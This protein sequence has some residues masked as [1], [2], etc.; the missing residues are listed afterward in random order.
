MTTT[1]ENEL[2]VVASCPGMTGIFEQG[3]ALEEKGVLGALALDY[4]FDLSSVPY[5]WLP[6]NSLKKYL[7]KYYSSSLSLSK[8]YT[9]PFYSTFVRLHNRLSRDSQKKNQLVYWHNEKF[10]KWVAKNVLEK[11]NLAFGY[12]STSLYTF[13]QAKQSNLPCILY[14]PIACAEKALELLDE[15]RK[16]FPQFANTL[17]YNWFPPEEIKNKKEE[18]FLADAIICASTFTK[19]SL[20]EQGVKAEKIFVEPYGVDQ[21][22]FSPSKEKYTNFSVIWASSYTQ[23]KGIVYLLEALARKPVPN[24]ELVLAGYPFGSDPVLMYEDQVKVNRIGKVSNEEISKIMRKC[25]VHVFPTLVEGFGRNLIE[26]MSSGLPVIT[27]PNCAGP[28]LIEDGVTGF[29]VPIRD[30]DAICEKLLWIYKNPEPS[31]EMG[32]RAKERVASLTK[33]N[34]RHRFAD[35]VFSVWKANR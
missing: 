33:A 32:Q 7:R 28:D 3:V 1:Y 21:E 22:L 26:A 12:E 9:H 11:G 15:E 35:R 27:T 8:I 16:R 10:D 6:D 13:R 24:I 2:K 23:T 4:Y 25:H 30:V 5:K 20:I 29:I 14:Q 18:R 34:Y 19:N 17:R 31:M